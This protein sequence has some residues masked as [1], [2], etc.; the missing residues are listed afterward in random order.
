MK[1]HYFYRLEYDGYGVYCT[2]LCINLNIH[3]NDDNHPAPIKQKGIKRYTGDDE[4]N[5]FWNLS[6]MQKWFAPEL[7]QLLLKNGAKIVRKKGILTAKS[8]YQCLFKPC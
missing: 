2:H 4:R 1:T 8:E 6:Q 3:H 7:I 5:G